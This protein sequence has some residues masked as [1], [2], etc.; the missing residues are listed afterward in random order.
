MK[1]CLLLFFSLSF[2]LP[3]VTARPPDDSLL[4]KLKLTKEQKLILKGLISEYKQEEKKRQTILRL[5]MYRFLTPAQ[6]AVLRRRMAGRLKKSKAA[7][8]KQ[9]A[10]LLSGFSMVRLVI[11]F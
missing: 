10:A 7:Y 1:Q 11:S 3:K 2:F 6:Q 9:K 8:N 4:L 5:K